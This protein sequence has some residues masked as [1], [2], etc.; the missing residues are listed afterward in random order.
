LDK[1]EE[2]K[3]D[4]I[5]KAVVGPNFGKTIDRCAQCLKSGG[6]VAYPTESFYGLAV[7]TT[8]ERAIQRL[9]LV[10][11]RKSDHPILILIPSVD[12]LEKYVVKV[13]EVARS[14]I[15]MF[16]P[17]GL[18]MVFRASP[19]ISGKAACRSAE[20]VLGMFG[21]RVDLVLDGGRTSGKAGSTV[22]DV[23]VDPPRVLR[24]GMIRRYQLE[25]FIRG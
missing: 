6:V 15:G 11:G 17:G 7:D 1:I 8:N 5:I 25:K 2:G 4:L 24:E 19:N 9:F 20:A 16:W 13:P 12:V 22:L 14:L 10:K 23:T 21:G 3:E 18:T